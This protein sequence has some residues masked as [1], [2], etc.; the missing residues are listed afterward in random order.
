M[1]RTLRL[2]DRLRTLFARARSIP[3][4]EL[5][6]HQEPVWEVEDFSGAEAAA[7]TIKDPWETEPKDPR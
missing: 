6:K 7:P 3:G 1:T 2:A 4:H 5:A